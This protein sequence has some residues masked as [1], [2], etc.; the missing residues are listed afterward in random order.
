[1]VGV[2]EERKKILRERGYVN[3]LS[4]DRYCEIL[5]TVPVPIDKITSIETTTPD[6][7]AHIGN[8]SNSIDFGAH[9]G[10]LSLSPGVG[11]V[12]KIKDDSYVGGD[13]PKYWNDGN[14]VDIKHK[15]GI[16]SHLE[17]FMYK[18]VM[19]SENQFVHP[20]QPIALIGATGY[21]GFVDGVPDYHVHYEVQEFYGPGEEDY[22]TLKPRFIGGYTLGHKFVRGF[23]DIFAGESFEEFKKTQIITRQ[24]ET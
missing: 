23:P 17:H 24:K 21:V 8:L 7:D 12:V 14:Y 5:F 15:N 2:S 19:V 18:S 3:D 1:M 4:T 16:V 10:T 13:D 6:N 22:I 9:I 11:E 20:G